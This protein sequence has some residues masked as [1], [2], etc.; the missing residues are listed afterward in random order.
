MTHRP[1]KV[2]YSDFRKAVCQYR[3]SD[4]LTALAKLSPDISAPDADKNDW[5]RL[6]PYGIAAMA[7]ESVLYGNEKL[8]ARAVGEPE[9]LKLHAIFTASYDGPQVSKKIIDSRLAI[10]IRLA[11]EQFRFQESDYEELTRCVAVFRHALTVTPNPRITSEQVD[12]LLGVPLEEAISAG[13]ALNCLMAGTGGIWID[14]FADSPALQE[15]FEVVTPNSVMRLKDELTLDISD[16]RKHYLEISDANPVPKHLERWGYS[17]LVAY[18]LV[19]LPNGVVVAPLSRL[20]LMRLSV[21]SLGYSGSKLYPDFLTHLG[22]VVEAY[23]GQLLNLLQGEREVVQQVM[24]G[25]SDNEGKSIDWFLVLPNCVLLVEVK[26]A[27][28]SVSIR[29]GDPLNQ[30]DILSRF[31]AARKQI[32]TTYKKFQKGHAALSAIPRDRPVFGI[33]VTSANLHVAN[34]SD[35][36]DSLIPTM[37]PVLTMSLRDLEH[38]APNDAAEFGSA[39]ETVINDP[40]KRTWPAHTSIGGYLKDRVNPIAEMAVSQIAM[41]AWA[42]KA[43]EDLKREAN[44]AEGLE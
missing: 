35:L 15:I 33:I 10:I 27:N 16:M 19:K 24:W 41:L 13:I 5:H 17:P 43:P 34:S 23:V 11:Y 40:D 18:P 31:N 32:N 30:A 21:T 20:I 6:S 36:T 3:P 8:K 26:L 29:A 25:R 37:I 28:F 42:D 9:I 38:F 22:E 4:L 39:V 14:E 12:S 1:S 7:R 44:G 2:R